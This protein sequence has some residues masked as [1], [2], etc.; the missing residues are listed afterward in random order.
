[1]AYA[2]ARRKRLASAICCFCD[3][4]HLFA[5]WRLTVPSAPDLDEQAGSANPEWRAAVGARF[6]ARN[7]ISTIYFF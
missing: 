6:C 2:P 7:E 4:A 5:L 3:Y 1:V